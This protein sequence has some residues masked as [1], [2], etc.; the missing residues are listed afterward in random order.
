LWNT[1]HGSGAIRY[2]D[3]LELPDA[4]HIY[5]EMA[6]PDGSHD[7]RVWRVQR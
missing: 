4:M 1:P 3:V 7:L 6:L 2:F 5:Y